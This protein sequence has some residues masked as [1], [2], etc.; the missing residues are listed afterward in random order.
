MSSNLNVTVVRITVII[1]TYKCWSIETNIVKKELLNFKISKED[2]YFNI[3]IIRILFYGFFLIKLPGILGFTYYLNLSDDLFVGSGFLINL[4]VKN[5]IKEHQAILVGLYSISTVFSMFGLLTT[6]STMMVFAISFIFFSIPKAYSSN[7]YLYLPLLSIMFFM[8]FSGSGQ[9]IS[10]DSLIWRNK[11]RKIKNFERY[12]TTKMCQLV[13]VNYFF[14]SGFFKLVKT[15]PEWFMG[16]TLVNNF[17]CSEFVRSD[18]VKKEV[19]DQRFN[20]LAYEWKSFF[21][22]A[23]LISILAECLTPLM[24][25]NGKAR[26]YLVAFFI[27]FQLLAFYLLF[28]DGSINVP[29]YFFWINWRFLFL[30]T[31]FKVRALKRIFWQSNL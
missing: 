1:K 27:A 16:N 22:F 7:L 31:K 9:Y 26:I 25:F 5:F 6:I 14:S 15:G 4:D 28:I 17:V 21:N 8:I 30:K 13:F 19:I 24:L 18:F 29:L 23:G 12:W 2:H 10:L 3:S 11:K 20:F